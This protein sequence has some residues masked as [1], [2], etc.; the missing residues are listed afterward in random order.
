MSELQINTRVLIILSTYLIHMKSAL[1][2]I[3]YS[4]QRKSIK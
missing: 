2:T 4:A 3:N 1:Q